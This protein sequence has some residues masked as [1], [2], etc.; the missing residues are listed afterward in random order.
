MSMSVSHKWDV[1]TFSI[2]RFRR[3]LMG[4]WSF[5]CAMKMV[6][7]SR[8]GRDDSLMN[9]SYTFLSGGV[10]NKPTDTS[11]AMRMNAISNPVHRFN[12]Y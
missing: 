10:R 7:R 3:W 11:L 6:K 5:D 2:A 4:Y 8:S 12:I 1:R 9:L